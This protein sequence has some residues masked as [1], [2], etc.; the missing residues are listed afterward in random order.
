[1]SQDGR[2]VIAV[3]QPVGNFSTPVLHSSLAFHRNPP[4]FP[5]QIPP[6]EHSNGVEGGWVDLEGPVLRKGRFYGNWVFI[7][8]QQLSGLPLGDSLLAGLQ[9]AAFMLRIH[10][11]HAHTS[12]KKTGSHAIKKLKKLQWRLPEGHSVSI[13]LHKN[14]KQG[15]IATFQHLQVSMHQRELL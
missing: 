15:K 13:V 8:P 2:S 9:N 7:L 1:M 5:Q 14:P 4:P 10:Y 6:Q 12:K 11:T 3:L